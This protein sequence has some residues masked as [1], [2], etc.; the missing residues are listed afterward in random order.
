M[1]SVGIRSSASGC[2]DACSSR[3]EII[4]GAGIAVALG[5]IIWTAWLRWAASIVALVAGYQMIMTHWGYPLNRT[6]PGQ[7]G[8]SGQLHLEWSG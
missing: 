6:G 8:L 5:V 3:R 7:G 2:P 4:L 1:P